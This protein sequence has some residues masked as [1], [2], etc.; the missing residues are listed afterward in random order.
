[1]INPASI[2]FLILFVV[3]TF[4]VY[5]AIRRGWLTIPV[6]AVVGG[7]ANVTFFSLYSISQNNDFGR[8]ILVGPLMGLVFTGATVAAAA[9]FRQNDG[10]GK[11]AAAHAIGTTPSQGEPPVQNP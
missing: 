5:V 7:I 3:T 10:K 9:F 6:S 2:I 11:I 1:M 4:L 8:V